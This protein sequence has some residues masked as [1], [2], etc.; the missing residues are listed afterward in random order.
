M[1]SRPVRPGEPARSARSARSTRP[2]RAV[3]S[4]PPTGS[5]S[6]TR[7]G[8]PVDSISP[9]E[10]LARFARHQ[11]NLV[12]RAQALSVGLSKDQLWRRVRNGHLVEVQPRVYRLRFADAGA[13]QAIRAAVMSSGGAASHLSAAWLHGLVSGAPGRP[14]VSLPRDRGFRGRG[15]EVHRPCDWSP[16]DLGE[17]EGITVTGPV[18]T[19]VDVGASVTATRLLRIVERGL[20]QELFT[21][22]DV[23]RRLASLA[24]QGRTGAGPLR[25]LLAVRSADLAASES[26]LESLLWDVIR[27]SELPLPERQVPVEFAGRRYRLDL[28]YRAERIALEGDGFGVHTR[29]ATFVRDHRRQN[30]LLLAGWLVIRFTWEHIVQRPDYLVETVQAALEARKVG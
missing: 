18:R 11:D 20:N 13:R 14:H 30:D 1:S 26:D 25:Q 17:V 2:P 29:R 27:R 6:S 16:E 12:T 19:V 22:E 8:T 23:K 4:G 24:R 10:A 15:V 28:A 9:D 3:G 21:V 7:S 5:A